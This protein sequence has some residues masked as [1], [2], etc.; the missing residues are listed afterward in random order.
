M[1]TRTAMNRA[2]TTTSVAIP[3]PDTATGRTGVWGF[4]VSGAPAGHVVGDGQVAPDV[5]T[6][7]SVPKMTAHPPTLAVNALSHSVVDATSRHVVVVDGPV[8]G[9]KVPLV[10]EDTQVRQHDPGSNVQF[11]EQPSPLIRL[12]S[13]HCSPISGVT[14]LSPH[15]GHSVPTQGAPKTHVLDRVPSTEHTVPLD[16]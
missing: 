1:F 13:S 11:D 10:P 6:E 3:T 14:T 5:N 12:P 9:R 16:W 7:V 15:T 2:E 4:C 8:V